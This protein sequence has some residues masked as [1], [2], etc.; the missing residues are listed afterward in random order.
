MGACAEL[1]ETT[2]L[3]ILKNKEPLVDLEHG[4]FKSLAAAIQKLKSISSEIVLSSFLFACSHSLIE[5][6]SLIY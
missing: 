5:H 3:N 1:S 2:L 4:H 6:Y